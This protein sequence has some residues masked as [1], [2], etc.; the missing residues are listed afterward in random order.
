MAVNKAGRWNGKKR[1]WEEAE[2][3][4]RM[5][6]IKRYERNSQRVDVGKDGTRKRKKRGKKG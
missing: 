6:G 1:G 5:E 4:R 2:D 3:R